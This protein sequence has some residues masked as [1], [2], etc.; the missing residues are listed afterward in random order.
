M[1]SD[2]L[3]HPSHHEGMANVILEASASARPVSAS[4]IPG[5]MESVLDGRSGFLFESKN[6]ADLSSKMAAFIHLPYKERERMGINAREYMQRH[7]GRDKIN[8]IF[9][10][11][12][13]SS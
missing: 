1:M 4:N 6:V 3:V 12:I 8:K 10:D 9:L 2:C 13:E 7:F 11:L 5:C